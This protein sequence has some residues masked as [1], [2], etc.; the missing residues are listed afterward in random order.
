M[1]P[2]TARKVNRR[3]ENPGNS[4]ANLN[5]YQPLAEMMKRGI[6]GR[7][8]KETKDNKRRKK[9]AQ[10]SLADCE[11]VGLY[12]SLNPVKIE[13]LLRES[14]I[15]RM[16]KYQDNLGEEVRKKNKAME[17]VNKRKRTN[18]SFKNFLNE[19]KNS[20]HKNTMTRRDRNNSRMEGFLFTFNNLN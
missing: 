10:M 20:Y 14:Q 4:F 11:S 19:K 13:N 18:N 3:R 8:S 16:E 9:Q 17:S 2:G 1:N 5:R 6:S 7:K 12:S 15:L